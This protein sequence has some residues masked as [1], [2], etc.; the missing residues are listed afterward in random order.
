[1]LMCVHGELVASYISYL[2]CQGEVG[3]YVKLRNCTKVSSGR[4]CMVD[5]AMEISIAGISC[6]SL[7]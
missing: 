6:S 2:G 5:A 7:F 3:R 4:P 1:M